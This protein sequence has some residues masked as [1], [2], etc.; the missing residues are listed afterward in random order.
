MVPPSCMKAQGG[1]PAVN[2]R[3]SR[4]RPLFWMVLAWPV[5]NLPGE[6]QSCNALQCLHSLSLSLSCLY[7]KGQLLSAWRSCPWTCY[8]SG[9]LAQGAA[10]SDAQTLLGGVPVKASPSLVLWQLSLII[11]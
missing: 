4:G 7:A 11:P 1:L 3:I 9:G 6:C 5:G 2:V 10:R 8:P